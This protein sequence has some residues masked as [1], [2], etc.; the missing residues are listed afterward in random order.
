MHNKN[1]QQS[2]FGVIL[3]ILILAAIGTVAAGAAI[4]VNEA[5][6]K[7]ASEVAQNNANQHAIDAKAAAAK[8]KFEKKNDPS[9]TPL[10]SVSPAPSTGPTVK[11]VV[12]VKPTTV[13]TAKPVTSNA[14]LFTMANCNG[15]STVY[16]SNKNGAQASHN[17][18]EQWSAYKTYPYGSALNVY[19]Q[20]DGNASGSASAY[21]PNYV[22]YIDAFIKSSDL[23]PTKL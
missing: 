1:K 18:P 14:T 10:V 5:K 22:T 23:S 8:K 3:I 20:L 19:C 15:N 9:P 17:S 2:G 13:P 6:S 7:K 4:K 21:A 11:P 16:V 12:T